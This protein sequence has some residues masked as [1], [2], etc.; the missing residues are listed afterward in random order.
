MSAVVTSPDRPP[1]TARQTVRPV[2][3]GFGPIPFRR[4]L[5]VEL[6]KMFDTRAG[7][8]LMAGDRGSAP[9]WPPASVVGVRARRRGIAYGTFGAAIGIPMAVD[10]ADRRDPRGRPA[11]GASAAG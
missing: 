11:S 2:S 5:G 8:W 3:R 1:P 4:V 10:P 6:R 9:C 7:F